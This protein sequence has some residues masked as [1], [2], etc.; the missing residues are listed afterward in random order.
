MVKLV[1]VL[2]LF[3]LNVLAQSV[4]ADV[5]L[6]PAGDFTA[7][8]SSLQGYMV[9]KDGKLLLGKPLSVSAT[10]FKTGIDLRDEHML[11]YMG[12]KKNPVIK[13][14]KGMGKGGN[15]LAL[16]SFNGKSKK[17]KFS[18]TKN[19]GKVQIK[20]KIKLSDFGVEDI[21]YQGIGVEDEVVIN[22]SVPLK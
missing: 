8:S 11:K 1:L 3:A 6:F 19:S 7:K 20:L 17:T 18:Y 5:E 13:V 21:S 16:L 4:S 10:S 2:V 12:A 14:S 9:E 22:A 15:G